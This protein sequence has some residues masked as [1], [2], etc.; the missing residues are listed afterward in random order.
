VGIVMIPA[1]GIGFGNNVQCKGHI[2]TATGATC[3]Q[4][5]AA[6]IRHQFPISEPMGPLYPCLTCND[7]C[8][9]SL[10]R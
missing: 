8:G 9:R 6:L 2:H 7:S 1:L 4:E 10:G 3:M 5:P